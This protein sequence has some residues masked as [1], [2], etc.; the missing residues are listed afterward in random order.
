MLY[1]RING[2]NIKA[3]SVLKEMRLVG[4]NSIIYY[5]VLSWHGP[6]ILAVVAAEVEI[7]LGGVGAYKRVVRISVKTVGK[8]VSNVYHS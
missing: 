4:N 6:A 7:A 8:W 2:S 1:R 5:V 3:Y